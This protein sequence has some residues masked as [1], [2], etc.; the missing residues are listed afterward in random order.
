MPDTGRVLQAA[1]G[2]V[3]IASRATDRKPTA[4]ADDIDT[5]RLALEVVR[6]VLYSPRVFVFGRMV[7]PGTRYVMLC[8]VMLCYVMCGAQAPC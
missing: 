7:P 6:G 1:I 4:E 8:Y 2:I 5:S 3:G